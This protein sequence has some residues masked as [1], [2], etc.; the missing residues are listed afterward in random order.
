MGR[1]RSLRAGL[2]PAALAAVAL[3]GPGAAGAPAHTRL[4]AS[5]PG[6]GAVLSRAPDAVRLR[7]SEPLAASL[8]RAHVL[9]PDGRAVAGAHVRVDRA[10][11]RVMIVRLPRLGRGAYST[12]W[13]AVGT[14]DPH[15]AR[16]LVVFRVGPGA[17]PA[18]TAPRDPPPLLAV[19]VRWVHFALL[20]GLIGALAVVGLVLRPA[21][22]GAAARRAE[23]RLLTLAAA[24]GVTALALGVFLLPLQALVLMAWE[25]GSS[26][27]LIGRTRWG[28]LWLAQ[29]A[30]LAAMVVAVILLRG[31]AHPAPRHP[32]VPGVT[33]I[34]APGPGVSVAAALAAAL[35]VVR[36][37]DGHAADV[38]PHTALSVVVLALHTLA[39]AVWVG[40]IVALVVGL[41]P[42]RREDMRTVWAPF[43]RLAAVSV[44]L[45][46]V[47]GLY[48]AGRQVA[49]VDALVTTL[50]GQGLGAK[51][52][53]LAVA[54]GFAAL[55]MLVRRIGARRVPRLRT[56]VIGEAAAGLVIIL[57]AALMSSAPPARGPEFDP[58]AAV[59][60]SQTSG[61]GDTLVT[62]SATPNRPGQNV[63]TAVVA[64]T[65]RPDPPPPRGLDLRFVDR[66]TSAAMREV[67]PGRFLLTGDQLSASGRS[68]IQ[69]VV[70]RPGEPDRTVDFAWTTGSAPRST[71]ISNRPL[72][73]VLTSAAALLALAAAAAAAAFAVSRRRPRGPVFDPPLRP[74]ADARKD[75]S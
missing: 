38:P 5:D 56:L 59:P 44:G 28:R 61:G 12:L 35:V 74:L 41:W 55:N 75:P 60:G 32:R 3:G 22:R 64:S 62:L 7:F 37:A 54:G 26:V 11:P 48:T 47:T 40:G 45:L 67:A 73:P 33:P 6:G 36:A 4:A 34:L 43:G 68:R 71:T 50:Y 20:A 58:A 42:L 10:D 51:A 49:S 53:L 63:L 18:S 52:V 29:E 24:C 1:S 23:G 65:R 39:A 31:A 30:L 69:A 19:L 15:R 13:T 46:A 2:V 14:T 66:G 16:G 27:E 70:H 25:P 9:A 17:A 21:R 57:A 8:S 72:E